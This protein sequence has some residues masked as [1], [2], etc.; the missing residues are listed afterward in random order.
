MAAIQYQHCGA[1]AATLRRQARR[2]EAVDALGDAAQWVVAR[3]RQWQRR[4]RD[5]AELAR[6]DDR[7]L[8]DIGL[9]RADAEFLIN[10]PF[11]R[12]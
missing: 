1:A 12:E 3:L 10:K 11:W 5:R 6:L 2:H 7:A 8:L 9:S 4:L